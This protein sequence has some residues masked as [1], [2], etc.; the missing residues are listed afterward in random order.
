VEL[1]LNLGWAVLATWMVISW[2]RRTPHAAED[3][4]GQFVALALVIVILLPA[5]SMTDDLIAARNPAEVDVSI[6]R[7]HDPAQGH[8][9]Q[10]ALA[11]M[12][13]SALLGLIF[14]P[15]CVC[16]PGFVRTPVLRTPVLASIDNR[17]PPAA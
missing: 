12:V 14:E 11:A 3:R 6:R 1:T 7:D 15:A 5:I 9:V 13:V 17:P 2:L 8:F 10:P 4:R 16:A